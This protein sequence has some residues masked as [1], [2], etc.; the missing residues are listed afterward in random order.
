MNIY[1]RYFFRA[2]LKMEES[3]FIVKIVYVKHCIVLTNHDD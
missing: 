3:G 1:V 2:D